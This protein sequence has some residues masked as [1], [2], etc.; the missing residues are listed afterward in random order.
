MAAKC[1]VISEQYI[2]HMSPVIALT[3]WDR[4]LLKSKCSCSLTSRLSWRCTSTCCCA[5]AAAHSTGTIYKLEPC[6]HGFRRNRK[7]RMQP[8]PS[9]YPSSIRLY[10]VFSNTRKRSASGT[11]IGSGICSLE[12]GLLCITL[13]RA[14]SLRRL[15][16]H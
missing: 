3:S 8:L 10:N 16:S 7:N 14:P 13:R 1:Y 5:H 2:R 15:T 4:S 12:Q 11:G 9:G 6:S